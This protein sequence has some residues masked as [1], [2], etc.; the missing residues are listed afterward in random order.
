MNI[1]VQGVREGSF[2]DALRVTRDALRK[3]TER[4]FPERQLIYRSQARVR[5]LS[6]S[7]QAQMAISAFA[8]VATG[9][10][11]FASSHV[12][13]S[14]KVIDAKDEQI[15]AMETA[16]DSLTGEWENAQQ[17]FLGGYWRSR[18]E[19]QSTPRNI[20]AT[21]QPGEETRFAIV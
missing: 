5:Y 10:V 9:W 13:L 8:I 11:V 2:R 4:A 21:R 6:L 19:A 7:R 15:A 1:G 12:Y 20:S 3:T 18:S 17:R 14:G 16:Y